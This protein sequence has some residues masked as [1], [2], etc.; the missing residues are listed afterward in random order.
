MN[1][2]DPA[3]HT[4]NALMQSVRK[5]GESTGLL[6]NGYTESP[7]KIAERWARWKARADAFEAQKK[8]EMVTVDLHFDKVLK[9]G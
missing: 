5:F 6:Y 3:N 9:V 1:T 4:H 7:E 8:S 2:L